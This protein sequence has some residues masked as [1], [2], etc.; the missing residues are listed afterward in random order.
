MKSN[1]PRN[2]RIKK[3]TRHCFH[4]ILPQLFPIVGLREDVLSQ[5]LGA[6]TTIG[7]LHDLEH[8]LRHMPTG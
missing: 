4:N 1:L 7:F 8:K 3:I 5:A 6:V 2:T